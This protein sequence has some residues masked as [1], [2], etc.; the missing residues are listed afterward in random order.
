MLEYLHVTASSQV[1][2][3]HAETWK[4]YRERISIKEVQHI[5]IDIRA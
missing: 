2:K 3:E 1:L 4:H 5:S